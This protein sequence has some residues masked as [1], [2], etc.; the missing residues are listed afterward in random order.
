MIEVER[1]SGKVMT[2][3]ALKRAGF[4]EPDMPEVPL[5]R[6]YIPENAPCRI[7]RGDRVTYVPKR[8]P[9]KGRGLYAFDIQP[10]Q[11]R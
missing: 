2:Y 3:D 11:S 1:E 8:R 5:V 10:E 9:H 4:I 6:F 7:E